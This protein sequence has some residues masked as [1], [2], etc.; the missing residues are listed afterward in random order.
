MADEVVAR[1]YA[2]ALVLSARGREDMERILAE[3]VAVRDSFRK[4]AGLHGLLMNPVVKESEKEGI[5][6][7]VFKGRVDDRIYRFLQAIF[8]RR[9]VRLFEEIVDETRHAIDRL[10]GRHRAKVISACPLPDDLRAR[11]HATLERTTGYTLDMRF[12]EDPAMI[13]GLYVHIDDMVLDARFSRSLSALRDRL[14]NDRL[15]LMAPGASDGG[16]IL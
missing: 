13:G 6:E 12:K 9:R 14:L 1:R 8:R 7:R 2:E 5:V 11:I 10:L 4:V 16:K 15:L 3:L